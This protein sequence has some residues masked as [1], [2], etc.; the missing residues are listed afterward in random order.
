MKQ[1][2]VMN[3][4]N[5]M[6]LLDPCIIGVDYFNNVAK[7]LL[8]EL[9]FEYAIIGQPKSENIQIIEVKTAIHKEKIID[10][11]EYD[12]K[13]TPCEKVFSGRRVCIYPEDVDKKFPKDLLLKEMGIKSYIG[14][15]LIG[16]KNQL[17]GI[18]VLLDKKSLKKEIYLNPQFMFV[19]ESVASRLTYEIGMGQSRNGM[20]N[21]T[22]ELSHEIYNPLN[23]ILNGNVL[24]Q[25]ALNELKDL[26]SEISHKLSFEDNDRFDFAIS[27]LSQG[28]DYVFNNGKRLEQVT[29]SILKK[30]KSDSSFKEEQ[31]ENP[32]HCC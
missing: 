20:E 13:K 29:K 14:A 3:I 7:I 5:S 21:L 6:N 11:F 26:K 30:S 32:Y 15:P 19:I 28:S 24:F 1:S 8:K 16:K 31:N 9:N 25:E 2:I 12:L 23:I 10:N 4:L 18:L 22:E 27:Y 17:I